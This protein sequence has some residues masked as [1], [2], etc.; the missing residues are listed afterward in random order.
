MLAL[1][2]KAYYGGILSGIAASAEVRGQP[3]NN[4]LEKLAELLREALSTGGSEKSVLDR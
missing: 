4:I 1:Q 3:T 2:Q